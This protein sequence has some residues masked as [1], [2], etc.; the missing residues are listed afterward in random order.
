MLASRSSTL[1]R[2]SRCDGASQMGHDQV[3]NRSTVPLKL[4]RSAGTSARAMLKGS[5]AAAASRGIGVLDLESRV[6]QRLDVVHTTSVEIRQALGI[7][8]DLD[9]VM[10][11]H[12]VAGGWRIH[13]HG[14]FHARAA[15]A[16]H[17]QAQ[18]GMHLRALAFQK[19]AQVFDGVLCDG[20]HG[21][22]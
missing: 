10:V 13:L 21:M 14:V 17:R 7:D 1:L 9:A 11:E 2:A 15:A 22:Q 20:N 3:C 8:D 6:V 16:L 5:A 12:L 4:A 18:T 19:L